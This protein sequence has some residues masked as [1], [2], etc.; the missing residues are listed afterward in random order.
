MVCRCIPEKPLGDVQKFGILHT[1]KIKHRLRM[2]IFTILSLMSKRSRRHRKASS[3]SWLVRLKRSP[4]ICRP[5]HGRKPARPRFPTTGGRQR[6][7]MQR[8]SFAPR[9]SARAGRS[10]AAWAGGLA[11]PTRLD[12]GRRPEL[13]R[14]RP[15]W[16]G[17]AFAPDFCALV[18]AG[19]VATFRSGVSPV[20]GMS[21]SRHDIVTR[22]Q[23][24]F[25]DKPLR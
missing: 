23:Q 22:A 2:T 14:G 4:T 6:R 13:V 3:G 19:A 15:D 8:V 10:A 20:G 7:A 12:R 9:A 18:R 25:A 16:R 11:A 1:Y 24:P 5:G 17:S 21:F